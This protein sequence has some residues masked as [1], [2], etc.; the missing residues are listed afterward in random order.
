MVGGEHM[1]QAGVDRRRQVVGGL[2]VIVEAGRRDAHS[3]PRS[4]TGHRGRFSPKRSQ[5]VILSAGRP[6]GATP[7]R[8]VGWP[9]GSRARTS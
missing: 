4:G 1:V 3:D 2:G 9:R 8:P 5:E 6:R 7:Q